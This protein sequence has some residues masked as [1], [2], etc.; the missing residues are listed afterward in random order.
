MKITDVQAITL[1]IP[2]QPMTPPSPWV[3]GGRKQI[4][5]R[6]LTDEGRSDPEAGYLKTDTAEWLS[7]H[8]DPASYKA[9]R[10]KY[11]ASPTK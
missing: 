7:S 8:F 4:V 10:R 2:M 9:K 11:F 3:A 6:V 5:V 1:A